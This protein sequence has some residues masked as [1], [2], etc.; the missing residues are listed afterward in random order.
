MNI[1]SGIDTTFVL[2]ILISFFLLSGVLYSNAYFE[3]YSTLDFSS[4]VKWLK[5]NIVANFYR[6]WWILGLCISITALTV[7][8]L[9]CT[10][11]KT[12]I[13]IKNRNVLSKKQLIG[14][15]CI[16]AVHI[17]SILIISSH[18]ISSQFSQITIFPV[19]KNGDT[20][21]LDN[22]DLHVTHIYY[23]YF[24]ENTLLKNYVKEI[25]IQLADRNDRTQYMISSLS[26]LSY[27]GYTLFLNQKQT[28][29]EHKNKAHV[30]T[31]V[32]SPQLSL[33]VKKDYGY[34]IWLLSF[35]SIIV[36]MSFFYFVI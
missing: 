36:L 26:P 20:I 9:L 2:L 24:P 27:H 34:E 16:T 35:I 13:V 17:I 29:N 4:I 28:K 12:V 8:M 15:L 23:V 19:Q 22:N 3:F 7:N 11:S 30:L 10:I 14:K 31:S 32:A 18:F 25:S 33:L 5:N 1:I 6:I 21:H